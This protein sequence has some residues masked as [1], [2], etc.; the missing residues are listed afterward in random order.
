MK[1]ILLTTIAGWLARVLAIALNVISMPIVLHSLGPTRFGIML[2]S[3]SVGSWIGLGN[4]GF[5]RVVAIVTARYYRKSPAFVATVVSHLAAI[6]ARFYVAL[7]AVFTG[8]FL[9][10]MP[11]IELGVD[12]A[13]YA[14]EFAAGTIGVFFTMALWFFL[15][16]FEGIDAGRHELFRLYRIQVFTYAATLLLMFT[17]F[18]ARPSLLFATLLLGSGGLLGNLIHALDVLRRH[19]GLFRPQAGPRHSLGRALIYNSLDF[20]IISMAISIIFQFTTGVVGLIVGPDEII[21]LGVFMRIMNSAGAV[22][23]TV[24]YPMS[25]LIASRIAHQNRPGAA[26][27]ALWTGAG[28][29]LCVGVAAAVFGVVGEQLLSLWLKAP[30]TY[31]P[32]FRLLASLL[33]FLTAVYAYAAGV[34]IGYG[35][36]RAVARVHAVVA[37]AVLPASYLCFRSIGQAGILLAIDMVLL[38]TAIACILS[39]REFKPLR[40]ALRPAAAAIA[41][42]TKRRAPE[43]SR[44][45]LN[46]DRGEPR[47]DS[48][49]KS[50]I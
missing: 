3:L 44:L 15:A 40:A 25:N 46:S 45:K 4:A 38:A 43:K 5:G 19:R 27:V 1:S 17:A 34:A 28:L 33:V 14:T 48:R 24:T 30:V 42:W 2:I 7:F 22:I 36:L 13:V 20:T 26:K 39:V 6:S 10:F 32:A 49:L 47:S 41:A 8:A 9:F 11:R 23:L 31:D 29:L 12:G 16:V 50:T 35:K 37:A 18:R 21:N